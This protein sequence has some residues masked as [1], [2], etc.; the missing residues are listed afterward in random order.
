MK[1]KI[2]I[3]ES[4][5]REMI[6]NAINESMEESENEGFFNN[7]RAGVNAGVNGKIDYHKDPNSKDAVSQLANNWGQ[8]FGNFKQ[9]YNLQKQNSKMD[10]L[11]QDLK[12][13]V[14]DGSINPNQTVQQLIA[15]F[16]GL[17][18]I[19]ANNQRQAK[20]MGMSRRLNETIDRILDEYINK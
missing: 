13:L 14:D 10:K 7:M 6:I 3:T 19:K 4:E 12:Q 20:K 18:N 15:N 1:Q 5:L 17:S 11:K 2:N 8:R 9:G 16:G